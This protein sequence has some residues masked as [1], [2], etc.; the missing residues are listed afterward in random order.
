MDEEFLVMLT[1][2]ELQYLQNLILDFGS[3]R[4]PREMLRRV[5]AKLVVPHTI[6][7]V[8]IPVP[9]IPCIRSLFP[10]R[11]RISA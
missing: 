2:E 1:K 9:S 3:Y 8:D 11:L 6:R 4:E 10:D 7:D 5:N